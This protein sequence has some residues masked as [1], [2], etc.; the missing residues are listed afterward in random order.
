M[1]DDATPRSAPAAD[2]LDA[3]RSY[4]RRAGRVAATALLGRLADAAD[5]GASRNELA[6]IAA[7]ALAE[8]PTLH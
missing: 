7:R 5:D 2:F 3:L 1:M 6:R 4:Y 8:L